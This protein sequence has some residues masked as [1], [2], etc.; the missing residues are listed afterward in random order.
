MLLRSALWSIVVVGLALPALG[1]EPPRHQSLYALYFAEVVRVIDGDT[2]DVRV[3]LWP[4]LEAIYAV[5]VR[6]VDAPEL[7]RV[8]CEA[9]QVWGEQAKAQV[10][11]LYAVGSLVRLENVEYDAFSGRVVA[12][13]RR[14]RSDRWLYLADE[15]V[16]RD[17]AVV[18]TPDMPDVPW[19]L[20]AET[21]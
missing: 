12:D 17:L 7:R 14:W 1:D 5:R 11:K 19:C 4:G 3:S 15:L 10:Q 13:V 20:L 2:L 18:W 8:G 9:E 6:G 21:R 16:E